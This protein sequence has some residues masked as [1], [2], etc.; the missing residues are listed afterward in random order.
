MPALLEGGIL[1]DVLLTYALL[2][3]RQGL[4][5]S[6]L[7]PA[8]GMK[9]V[10]S[11][12][13]RYIA[14]NSLATAGAALEDFHAGRIMYNKHT[15]TATGCAFGVAAV[16]SDLALLLVDSDTLG[17]TL[18]RVSHRELPLD[19]S[20]TFLDIIRVQLICCL[21]RCCH[22]ELGGSEKFSI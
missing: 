12:L 6:A 22:A 19:V 17:G 20:S 9:G 5:P 13:A 3:L 18:A 15:L 10:N 2:C 11:H 21:P 16:V 14:V 1:H 8:L 4:V 7:P